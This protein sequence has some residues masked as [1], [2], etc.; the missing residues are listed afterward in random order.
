MQNI[1][2]DFCQPLMCGYTMNYSNTS[3]S[4]YDQFVDGLTE[5]N[6]WQVIFDITLVRSLKSKTHLENEE[7]I[8]L[9]LSKIT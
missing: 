5:N 2:A 9:L 4:Y 8:Q 6:Q 7:F 3:V 1:L